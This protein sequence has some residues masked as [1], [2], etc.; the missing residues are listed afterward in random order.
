MLMQGGRGPRQM[1][2][3]SMG[4]VGRSTSDTGPHAP[5]VQAG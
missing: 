4:P 1:C 3:W 2:A 5:D